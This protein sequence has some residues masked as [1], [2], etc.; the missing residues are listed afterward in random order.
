MAEENKKAFEERQAA[1][2]ERNHSQVERH[3]AADARD[4]AAE[5]RDGIRPSLSYLLVLAA[6]KDKILNWLSVG[7][8]HARHSTIGES[9]AENTGMWLVEELQ[10]W[11]DGNGPRLVIC[12]GAGK[13]FR[14]SN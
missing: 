10:Q 5:E 2:E 13:V 7:D 11:F 12:Q 6:K 1:A 14:L 8:F 9:H 4:K 3:A